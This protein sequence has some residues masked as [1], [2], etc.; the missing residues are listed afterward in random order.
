MDSPGILLVG[1]GSFGFLYAK[2]LRDAGRLAG[3]A[4][5]RAETAQRLKREMSEPVGTSYEGMLDELRPAGVAV[6]SPTAAHAAHADVAIRRG[7][8]VLVIKPV[9]AHPK[10]AEELAARADAAKVPVFVAHEGVFAPPFK[11]LEAAVTSG[12]I[13]EVREVRWLKEGG[14]QLSGGRTME[15]RPEDEQGDNLGHTYATAMHELYAANRLAGR[16]APVKAEVAH[17]KASKATPLLDAVLEYPG[18]VVLRLRHDGRP[19]VPFRRGLHVVGTQGHV[20]WLMQ[21][22]KTTL[23]LKRGRDERD[24]PFSGGRGSLPAT[25]VVEAFLDVV[26]GKIAPPETIAD[27]VRALTAARLLTEAAAKR[28]GLTADLDKVAEGPDLPFP[29]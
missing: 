17:V 21:P 20:L 4:V 22:G 12:Q 6:L 2:A 13:G 15:L 16:I 29:G 26:A 11:A 3:V 24:V 28:L 1:H 23:K 5:R 18:G 25:A 8:P 19:E 10:T 14:E 9:T 7:L 27:G